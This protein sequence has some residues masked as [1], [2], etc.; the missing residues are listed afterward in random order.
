MVT[1][2]NRAAKRRR[3]CP[4]CRGGVIKNN[5]GDYECSACSMVWFPSDLLWVKS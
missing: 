3:V 5:I 2:N 4:A 1:S